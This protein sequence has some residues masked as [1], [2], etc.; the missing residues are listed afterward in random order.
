[1]EIEVYLISKKQGARREDMTESRDGDF[2]IGFW[3]K[4]ELLE[5]KM[6]IR[7]KVLVE[8]VGSVSFEFVESLVLMFGRGLL[9]LEFNFHRF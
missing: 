4:V 6:I 9:L 7:V 1:M 2:A 3:Y 5:F 8:E